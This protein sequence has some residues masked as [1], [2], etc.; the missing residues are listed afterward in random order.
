MVDELQR[1]RMHFQRLEGEYAWLAAEIQPVE[2]DL[3]ECQTRLWSRRTRTVRDVQQIAQPAETIEAGWVRELH[4]LDRQIEHAKQVLRDLAAAR[5]RLTLESTSHVCSETPDESVS[6]QLQ[7]NLLTRLEQQL[8]RLQSDSETHRTAHARGVCVCDSVLTAFDQQLSELRQTVYVLC[9]QIS[10]R[11]TVLGRQQWTQEHVRIEQCET[12]VLE[13][14]RRLR[15]R[16]EELLATSRN[17]LQSRVRHA[18]NHELLHCRCEQHAEFAS[19]LPA[20]SETIA[21][22]LQEIVTER[23]IEET[24][25]RS[26]DPAWEM[27]LLARRE[28]LRLRVNELQRRIRD[29]HQRIDD[30]LDEQRRFADDHSAMGLRFAH[31]RAKE[32]LASTHEQWTSLTLQRTVLSEAQRRL[33][34][35]EHSRVIAEAS[36]YLSRLTQ[37]R[38]TDFHFDA[39]L[40]ELFIR[41]AD[42]QLLPPSALS[43]GTLDQ[44]ALSFRLALV[45]E[46]ARRGVRLPL[47]L[48]D[49]LVDSDEHRLWAAIAVLREVAAAGQQVV[50]LT[51]Q[52]HLSDLFDENG[53]PVRSLFGGIRKAARP[54]TTHITPPSR[55]TT[56]VVA[57][58]ATAITAVLPTRIEPVRPVLQTAVHA[59]ETIVSPLPHTVENS[60]VPDASLR[61]RVQPEGPVL[62]ASG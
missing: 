56:E 49:V 53:Q 62:A 38:Y 33:H 27:S 7:R 22:P 25:A 58:S 45:A 43:R 48:D 51:C 55:S 52:E 30:L 15:S 35:E 20:E 39:A 28:E 16:R 57:S 13:R 19:R 40:K 11:Q 2:A 6:L 9:Q 21:R 31:Q 42:G 60:H 36:A 37:G 29:A 23:A 59:N 24:D 5:L 17:P 47:V 1:M 44:T 41:N 18:V 32:H 3:T 46:Y 14:I 10:Q 54:A 4:D 26:G 61:V 34:L 50:F 8:L 12:E